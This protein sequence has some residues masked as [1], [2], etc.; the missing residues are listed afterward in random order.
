ML[1]EVLREREAQ[2]VHKKHRQDLQ[3]LQEAKMIKLQEKVCLMRDV[4]KC[5]NSRSTGKRGC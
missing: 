5:F 4:L 1:S 3:A 2:L